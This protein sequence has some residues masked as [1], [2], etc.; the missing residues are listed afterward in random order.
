MFH[1]IMGIVLLYAAYRIFRRLE[2]PC[3]KNELSAMTARLLEQYQKDNL[4]LQDIRNNVELCN[5]IT[6]NALA[7]ERRAK[8]ALVRMMRDGG[9]T[10]DEIILA[11]A[12]INDDERND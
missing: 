6:Q 1:L 7:R 2:P 12:E 11:L 3:E 9:V 4:K 8:A 10:E 5:R